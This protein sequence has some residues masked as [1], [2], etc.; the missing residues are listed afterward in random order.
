MRFVLVH[1]SWQDE[2]CWSAVRGHLE[3]EGHEV[4]TLTLPGNGAKA[5]P[6][7]TMTQT[8]G[9]VA[10]L[11]ESRNLRD[12][13]LVGH[14]FGGAVVQVAALKVA[15]RL[16]RL[17]FYN[18]YVIENGRSVFSYVPASLAGAFQALA[19]PDR[20]LTLPFEFFR[21][22]FM[23]DADLPT[24]KAAYELTSPEPL[25]RSAETLD[26]TGFR[27]LR[28]PKSYLYAY[29]DNVF[30]AAEFTWHPGMSQRLGDFRLVVIPGGHE[31]MFSDPKAL[32]R[33]L[34]TASQD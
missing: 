2:R 34:V 6:A 3:A 33:G 19:S 24:A 12:V 1:G 7:V 27:E 13:I 32:A 16:K 14:S 25:G 30:P 23:N 26:L 22:H 20:T 5:N 31:L 21:D 10:E 15:E 9:A 4:H 17:V 8:A 11:I 28:V 29:G 18:A